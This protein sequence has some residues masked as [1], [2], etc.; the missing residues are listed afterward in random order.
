MYADAD[1]YLLDDVLSAV[2]AHVAEHLFRS[3]RDMLVKQ[4]RTVILVSHQVPLTARYAHKVV[5]MA[6]DGTVE[7]TGDPGMYVYI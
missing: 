6:R 1:I 4:G 3:I 2:D 7:E 5:L